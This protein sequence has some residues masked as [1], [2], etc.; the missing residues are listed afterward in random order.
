MTLMRIVCFD[1]LRLRLEQALGHN[2][3]VFHQ[4]DRALA[5]HDDQRL[6]AAME[7]LRLYPGEVRLQVEQVIMNWLFGERAAALS[8]PQMPERAAD[9][10][11]AGDPRPR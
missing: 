10:R 1:A 6:D 7:S 4:L 2:C 3:L 5:E 11:F 9:S 8:L